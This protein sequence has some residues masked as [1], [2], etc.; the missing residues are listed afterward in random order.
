MLLQIVFTTSEANPTT[1]SNRSYHYHRHFFSFF[2]SFSFFF[3]FF[4]FY[5]YYYYN[6]YNYYNYYTTATNGGQ[7][8]H[9]L[10]KFCSE[11][12]HNAAV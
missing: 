8:P 9:L 7:V 10:N 6:Y 2:F 1:A 11:Q 12:L 4:F 5:Y 3:F